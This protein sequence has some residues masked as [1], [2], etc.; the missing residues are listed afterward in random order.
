MPLGVPRFK[1]IPSDTLKVRDEMLSAQSPPY[2]KFFENTQVTR[3]WPLKEIRFSLQ[4]HRQL[5]GA[6]R[7]INSMANK[8][9]NGEGDAIAIYAEPVPNFQALPSSITAAQLVQPTK[10]E[11]YPETD[12]PEV[13]LKGHTVEELA[14]A[15][16]V[17][18]EVIKRAIKVRQQQMLVEKQMKSRTTTKKK[19]WKP[20][21]TPKQSTT[22]SESTE[23]V[24]TQSAVTKR[25]TTSYVPKPKKKVTKKPIKNGHKVRKLTSWLRKAISISIVR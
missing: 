3:V 22:S 1:T 6:E 9:V 14:E 10:V 25:S 24:T 13:D 20:S 2:P 18:V 19:F 16:N 7:F 5:T 17:S 12:L 8:G 15:A 21:T 11:F 4:T 23:E